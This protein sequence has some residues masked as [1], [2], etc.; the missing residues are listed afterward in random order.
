MAARASSKRPAR[1]SQRRGPTLI[2]L[3]RLNPLEIAAQVLERGV[4]LA[5]SR[6]ESRNISAC[7]RRH[8]EKFGSTLSAR[9]PGCG[10]HRHPERRAGASTVGVRGNRLWGARGARGC[11]ARMARRWG[12]T[13]GKGR[14]RGA[15]HLP[16]C[17]GVP[18]QAR[19]A[20][21]AQG[22]CGGAWS[23]AQS[24]SQPTVLNHQYEAQ[25]CPL[26]AA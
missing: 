24:D 16:L 17:K 6:Q 13:G 22:R 12:A 2:I 7:A 11:T 4:G 8:A 18:A 14:A 20:R 19:A 9:S 10:G 15:A 21:A 5:G 1:A 23:G 25:R 26:L 3:L